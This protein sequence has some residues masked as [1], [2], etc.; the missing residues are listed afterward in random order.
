LQEEPDDMDA[1]NILMASMS[2]RAGP[3][4]SLADLI[5]RQLDGARPAGATA[6]DVAQLSLRPGVA[7]RQG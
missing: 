5:A 1:A 2:R 3:T 7:P 4:I 6:I